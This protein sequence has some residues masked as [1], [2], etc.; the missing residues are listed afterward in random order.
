MIERGFGV[1]TQELFMRIFSEGSCCTFPSCERLGR[2]SAELQSPQER[3][4]IGY[5]RVKLIELLIFLDSACE[6]V[7]ALPCR[8]CSFAGTALAG[9]VCAYLC[10]NLHEHITIDQLSEHFGVSSTHLKSCFKAVYGDS[11]YSYT[12]TQKMLAA[13]ELLRTTDRTV[14]DIAGEYGYDNGSKFSKAFSSVM[15]VTPS[16]F[17]RSGA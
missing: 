7:S 8:N 4:N 12:K 13:A 2:L 11:I 9:Q 17:R 3:L 14:L 10:S 1:D 6:S 15:G 16:R 5:L